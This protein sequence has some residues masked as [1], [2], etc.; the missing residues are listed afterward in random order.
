MQF[1]FPNPG[2]DAPVSDRAQPAGHRS[3]NGTDSLL[4]PLEDEARLRPRAPPVPGADP[5]RRPGDALESGPQPATAPRS[6]GKYLVSPLVKAL[7]NG[8]FASSVS[9]R[10]GSGRGTTDHHSVNLP[11]TTSP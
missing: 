10:S 8:W 9:I 6:I 1:H 11:V 3:G 4:P 7:E 2:P 5:G